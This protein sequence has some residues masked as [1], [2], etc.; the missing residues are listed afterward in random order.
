MVRLPKEKA[1]TK[2]YIAPNNSSFINCL[3]FDIDKPDAG[4]SWLDN[5]IAMPNWI[6]QNPLNGHAHYGYMLKTPVSRTLKARGTPQRY[7][8]RIQQAMTEQLEADAGYAHF[9]TKTPA[10]DKHRTIWGR[11]EPFTLDELRDGLD[12]DLPLRLKRETAV[13]EGRNVTLFDGLRFWAY[14]ERLKYNDFDRWFT[15]CLSHAQALNQ[16]SC[17]LG[18]NELKS[19]AKSVA[20]WT[21]QNINANGL[22]KAQ[23]NRIRKRWAK[24]NAELIDIQGDLI[25]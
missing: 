11:S 17:P 2:P 25:R 9:L 12:A 6:C 7:L 24:N 1:I 16:F 3:L 19:T 20:K 10:H 5:N 13:G 18:Y 8:A 14:R 4:A 23:T 21:W 22:S 15:A